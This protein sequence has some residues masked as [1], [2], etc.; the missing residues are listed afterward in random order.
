MASEIKPTQITNL[1]FEDVRQDIVNQFLK[2]PEFKDA[3]FE[4]SALG[5]LT[6]VLAHVAQ[7]MGFMGHAVF[8]EWDPA[9]AQLRMSLVIAAKNQNY[10]PTRRFSSL[11]TVQISVPDF[12]PIYSEYPSFNIATDTLVLPRYSVFNSDEYQFI[13]TEEIILSQENSFTKS[14]VIMEGARSAGASLGTSDGTSLQH[15]EILLTSLAE[16]EFNLYVDG[17]PWTNEQDI[18]LY[19][20]TTKYYQVLE[21]YRGNYEV[22]FGDGNL[23]VIPDD[24][25]A[26]TIDYVNSAGRDGNNRSG[27]SLI[28]SFY[29]NGVQDEVHE[30]DNVNFLTTTIEKSHSGAD[31]ESIVSIATNYPRFYA[32]QKKATTIPDY[33]VLARRHPAVEYLS[34]YA[35]EDVNPPAYGYNFLTIKPTDGDILTPSQ[36][37]SIREYLEPFM[38]GG[39]ELRFRDP[40]YLYI[41]VDAILVHTNFVTSS[42]VAAKARTAMINHFNTIVTTGDCFLYSRTLD[43]LDDID[44]VTNSHLSIN[45][46]LT[47]EDSLD[48]TYYFDIGQ[49]ILP[50]SL[51][52]TI[53][54]NEGWY[55]DGN[56]TIFNKLDN[57]ELGTI[58]YT[59][60]IIDVFGYSLPSGTH[61]VYFDLE[62]KDAI[63]Y[64]NILI[65]FDESSSSFEGRLSNK[66]VRR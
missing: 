10:Y 45:T 57:S 30:I 51:D 48:D 41:S 46:Y 8:N 39:F 24:G 42:D 44:H 11:A 18:T 3:R 66:R 23:G 58:D 52:L 47:T 1:D 5:Y 35:G 37:A 29:V 4:Q 13:T 62:T 65:R 36:E 34:A 43:M 26:I 27:F 9:T 31:R 50:K 2:Y 14:F 16:Q 59:H 12:A 7:Y 49:P 19:D 17:D 22:R 55:D 54:T 21:N 38:V 15:K 25:A 63:V 61:K 28:G 53:N 60:G 32:S 56:G 40:M 64:Q 33:D 20:P 6:D